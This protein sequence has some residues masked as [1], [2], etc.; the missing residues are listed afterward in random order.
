MDSTLPRHDTGAS[1]L[2]RIAP[3]PLPGAPSR[4][5]RLRAADGWIKFMRR[6]WMEP[7]DQT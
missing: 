1:G 7:E 5:L 3:D 4:E 2:Q 6:F